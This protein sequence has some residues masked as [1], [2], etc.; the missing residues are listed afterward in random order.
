MTTAVCPG[1]FDPITLGHIDVARRARVMF[2]DVV[3]V[4]GINA[5][6]RTLFTVDERIELIRQAVVDIPGV[7]VDA[8]D[9]LIATYCREHGAA[10]IVKGLRGAA[11]YE[12]E[13]AMALM[14]RHLTGIETIFV[15]GDPALGHVASSLIKD[16]ARHGG[17]LSD[18]VPPGVAHALS[19][20]MASQAARK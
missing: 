19:E 2:D 11:D 6:K 18:L 17:D 3:I 7:R 8:T 15:M 12:G 16:V 10:A 5:S 9:G 20:R 4:V 14:N 13:Q 1:S